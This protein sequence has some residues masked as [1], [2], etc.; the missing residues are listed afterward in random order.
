MRR[1]RTSRGPPG[2]DPASRAETVMIQPKPSVP[3]LSGPSSHSPAADRDAER[4]QAGAEDE[5]EDLLRPDP[6][7]LEHLLWC[8]QVH[9]LQRW[10]AAEPV[11]NCARLGRNAV[12]AAPPMRVRLRTPAQRRLGR[13]RRATS[14]AGPR[15]LSLSGLTTDRMLWTRPAAMSRAITLITWA[16]AS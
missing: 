11:T 2:Q 13:V 7:S 3:T 6:W 5:G 4:D 12:H 14:D 16:L 15:W 9:D 8:G 1:Q 10:T